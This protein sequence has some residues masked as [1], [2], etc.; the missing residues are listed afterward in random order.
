MKSF[1]QRNPACHQKRSDCCQLKCGAVTS[2]TNQR[3]REAHCGVRVTV[4]R[5]E[6]DRSGHGATE[7]VQ[8][9]TSHVDA[10]RVTEL[11]NMAHPKEGVGR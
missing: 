9:A 1:A 4:G 6:G 8:P 10:G 3:V 2:V 11:L 7:K 5:L